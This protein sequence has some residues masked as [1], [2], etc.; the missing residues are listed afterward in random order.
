MKIRNKSY[1]LIK[2]LFSS[3]NVL[4]LH[5]FLT[6]DRTERRLIIIITS[7][8]LVQRREKDL[9]K[10]QTLIKA[11]VAEGSSKISM[12]SCRLFCYHAFSKSCCLVFLVEICLAVIVLRV[13]SPSVVGIVPSFPQ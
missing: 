1:F 10:I 9:L 2:L 6:H 4:H 8:R 12:S 11:V 5:S 7:P 3:L 13:P